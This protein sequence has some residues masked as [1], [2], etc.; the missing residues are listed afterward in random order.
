MVVIIQD[1]KSVFFGIKF[2]NL[3]LKDMDVELKEF[4]AKCNVKGENEELFKSDTL[5]FNNP[6]AFQLMSEESKR[7]WIHDDRHQQFFGFMVG[8][9]HTLDTGGNVWNCGTE[10]G[11]RYCDTNCYG[12]WARLWFY[13]LKYEK[14]FF[15]KI[16][17]DND[18]SDLL[19]GKKYIIMIDPLN[20]TLGWERMRQADKKAAEEMD[21]EKDMKVVESN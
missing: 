5:V 4:L 20:S 6:N 1:G 7:Y 21:L 3:L 10:P 11:S 2:C 19:T 12:E 17:L 14:D 16:E 13:S 9:K 8:C 18:K 15:D